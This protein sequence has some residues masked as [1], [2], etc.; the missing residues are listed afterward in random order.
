M[1]FRVIG[2]HVESGSLNNLVSIP[3]IK[4]IPELKGKRVGVMKGSMEEMFLRMAL[5]KYDIDPD[6]DVEIVY[7]E[8]PEVYAA[9]IAK[10]IDAGVPHFTHALELKRIYKYNILMTGTDLPKPPKPIS[11][12]GYN[13]IAVNRAWA[14]KNPDLV[15]KF[16]AL[17]YRAMDYYEKDPITLNKYCAEK[18]NAQHGTN[19]TDRDINDIF[20]LL[21]RYSLE[22]HIKVLFNPEHPEN[23]WNG[24]R[25]MCEVFVRLGR[26]NKIPDL[27]KYID[28]S[29]MKKLYEY[30]ENATLAIENAEKA[31]QK[32]SEVGGAILPANTLKEQAKEAL[33]KYNYWVALD[34]A[35]KAIESAETAEKTAKASKEELLKEINAVKESIKEA[36]NLVSKAIES[37][38]VAKNTAIAGIVIAVIAIAIAI[39]TVITYRKRVR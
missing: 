3:E 10:R 22:E 17:Y 5:S 31:I 26:I 16:L 36:N 23:V 34:L 37:A 15:V 20:N 14:E 35:K 39:F 24:A 38:E 29:Y 9:L 25:G 11:V 32:A 4:S 28:P 19:L 18:H 7:M 1:D 8:S 12:M 13:F 30:K 21:H 33:N 27:K 6:K 2:I